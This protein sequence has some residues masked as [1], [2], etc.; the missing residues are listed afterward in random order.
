MQTKRILS[1]LLLVILLL[2]CMI[3]PASAATEIELYNRNV[4]TIVA[5]M[6]ALYN[7]DITY[8]IRGS[9]YAAIGAP[10]LRTLD[11]SLKFITPEMVREIS[12]FY[13]F[14]RVGR[15]EIA[16]E[17]P[18]MSTSE[19]NS[20]LAAFN[21]AQGKL[22][23]FIPA[24]NGSMIISG[25]NPTAIVH[26]MGHALHYMLEGRVGGAATLQQ[27]WERVATSRYDYS[28]QNTVNPNELYFAT[29]Y[30]STDYSEDFAE[31]FALAFTSN[32]AGL[33]VS[34]RFKDNNGKDTVL[35]QKLAF[36]SNIIETHV[37]NNKQALANIELIYT[38]P[39]QIMY[40]DYKFSGAE[41]RYIGFSEPNGVYMA[42]E[43][44]LEITTKQSKWI[45]E[46]GAW[47][48]ES[49]TGKQLYAFPGGASVELN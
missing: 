40:N 5:E 43:N 27:M 29:S 47:W 16:F 8:P 42:I 6:E 49:S 4:A 20:A 14:K 30:A 17:Y 28:K 9:G 2:N 11:E 37:T 36:I 34:H 45:R 15:L 21:A 23:I 31:T 26:E 7:V 12:N 41:L 13:V 1:F 10:T 44:H 22:R 33:G 39:R 24:S 32:R 48:I 19:T 46:I 18:P 35:A 3:L 25:N 38:T